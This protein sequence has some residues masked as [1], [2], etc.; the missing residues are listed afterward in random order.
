[1]IKTL[2]E[3]LKGKKTY[4]VAGLAIAYGW[5]FSDANA[6]LLG[7]GL[8]GLRDGLSTEITKI[9]TNK[10]RDDNESAFK[11]PHS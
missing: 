5:Y 8:F 6:V 9:L 7:L 10:K 3:F 11:E 4:F 1:M 2:I